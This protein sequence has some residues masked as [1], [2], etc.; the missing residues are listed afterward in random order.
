M[1]VALNDDA[2]T[3]VAKVKYLWGR[4]QTDVTHDDRIATLIN[5]LST[6]IASWCGRT[7]IETTYTDQLY[8]GNGS[9]YLQLKQYPRTT[10]VTVVVKIDD[11]TV[12]TSDYKVYSEE[13]YIYKGSWW[14]NGK[15]N[16]KVTY[17]AGYAAIP[18]DL[19]MAVAEWAIILLER[20]YKDA[21]L[22]QITARLP[23]EF[24]PDSVVGA[25]MPYKRMDLP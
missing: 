3:T 20:R 21:K 2:L 16:I 11:V 5:F 4:D 22:L 25:L 12:D 18:E 8:D 6:R 7:F 17:S 24:I 14:P 9:P 15:Q 23:D 13:G 19:G 1:A 10:T